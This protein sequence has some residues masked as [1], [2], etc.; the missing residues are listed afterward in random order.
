MDNSINSINS[1][2]ID[3]LKKWDDD[4]IFL[5][6]FLALNVSVYTL[7][8]KSRYKNYTEIPDEIQE[9]LLKAEAVCSFP[10]SNFNLD[11]AGMQKEIEKLN[12]S[13][14]HACLD[15]AEPIGFEINTE[16]HIDNI[17]NILSEFHE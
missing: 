17:N 13:I 8:F 15:L 3:M 14:V 6:N 5:F 10:L 16:K 1:R 4:T 7:L 2:F 12:N 9:K 11:H